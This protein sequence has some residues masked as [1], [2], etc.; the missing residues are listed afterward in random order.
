MQYHSQ[1]LSL[2]FEQIEAEVADLV[3]T[4]ASGSPGDYAQYKYL[5]GQV[6]ALKSVSVWAEDVYNKLN[7]E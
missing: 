1:F 5:C 3:N 6:K 2:L 7:G 4:I